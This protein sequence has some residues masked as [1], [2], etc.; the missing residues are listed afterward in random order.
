MPPHDRNESEEE[1]YDRNWIEILQELRVSQT[2]V[3][4]IGGL[5]L[6]LPFQSRFSE[7]DR[8]QTGVYLGLVVLAAVTTGLTLAPIAVHRALFRQHHKERTVAVGHL[9]TKVIVPAIGL[10]MAGIVF[11]V[12]DVVLS[13]TWAASVGGVLVLVLVLLLGVLPRAMKRSQERLS[14][15]AG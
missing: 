11:L 13:R 9:L 6:T 7:L 14:G 1:K 8:F 3:Q 2:G 12:F 15:S 5:L 4:L 10:L